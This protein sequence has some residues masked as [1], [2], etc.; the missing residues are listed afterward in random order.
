MNSRRLRFYT[1]PAITSVGYRNQDTVAQRDKWGLTPEERTQFYSKLTALDFDKIAGQVAV[2]LGG[3]Y[4]GKEQFM[5][6]TGR[7]VL[8]ELAELVKPSS[9]GGI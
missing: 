3:Q 6:D 8:D 9:E 7:K 1:K 4:P 2:E 5:R